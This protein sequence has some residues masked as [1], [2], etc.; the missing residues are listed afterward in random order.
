MTRVKIIA[1]NDSGDEVNCNFQG[2]GNLTTPINA[3]EVSVYKFSI[4]NAGNPI[5]EWTDN[6]F[7]ITMT[8]DGE[9]FSQYAVWEDRGGAINGINFVYEI[10]HLCNMFNTAL[11]ACVTGLNLLKTL[12][13][14]VVPRV[15]YNVDNSRFEIVVIA[16]AYESTLAKPI[17]ITVNQPL[18]YVLQGIPIIGQVVGGVSVYEMIFK[19]IPENTYMSTYIKIVQ[20][21]ISISNYASVKEILISTSL[22][23]EGLIICTTGGDA[24]QSSINVIQSYTIP[25]S[26]GILDRCEDFNYVSPAD[27]YRP[28]KVTGNNIYTVKCD[29]YYVSRNGAI[30]PF[31]LPPYSSAS[32]E[33]E[34]R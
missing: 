21:S 31:I 28:C 24:G 4:P 9:T 30:R 16:S 3:T 10:D 32:I 18:F 19:Q 1:R 15:L 20:E 12:P 7:Q 5:M 11:T 13:S 33:L 22:P 34:F 8:Y 29:L 6:T 17:K 27:M 23:V 2:T 14:V 25:Y 26:N